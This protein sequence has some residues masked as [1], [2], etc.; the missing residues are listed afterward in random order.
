MKLEIREKIKW[1]CSQNLDLGPICDSL[2]TEESHA[3]YQRQNKIISTKKH[4]EMVI[5]RVNFLHYI[6]LYYIFLL[7]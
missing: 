4:L 3:I 1:Q 7:T 6:L 5:C 2:S